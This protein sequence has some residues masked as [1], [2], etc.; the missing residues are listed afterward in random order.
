M[1]RISLPIA[2]PT[3]SRVG[4]RAGIDGSF[5]PRIPEPQASAPVRKPTVIIM[6]DWTGWP[7]ARAA[8]GP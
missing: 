6:A 5:V 4:M 2:I 1:E 3:A 7:P 8:L